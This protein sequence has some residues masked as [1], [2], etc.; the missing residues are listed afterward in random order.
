MRCI[1]SSGWGRKP[2]HALLQK[3]CVSQE[4]SSP[5]SGGVPM[6]HVRNMRRRSHHMNISGVSSLSQWLGVSNAN[7]PATQANV[8]PQDDGPFASLNLSAQQQQQITQILQGAQSQGLPLSQVRSQ[9][10]AVLTPQQQAQLQQQQGHHRHHHGNTTTT[11]SPVTNTDEFGIPNNTSATPGLSAI[12]DLA[13][14][15][16]FQGGGLES[17]TQLE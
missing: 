4:K 13:A 17:N 5:F 15:F 14:S 8:S 7:A 16:Q 9:I 10:N 1:I 2:R 3:H 12:A 11:A 6:T